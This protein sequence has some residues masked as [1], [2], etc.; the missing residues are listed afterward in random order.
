MLE[1]TDDGYPPVSIEE[2][3]AE[4]I[5]EKTFRLTGIPIFAYGIAPGDVI[6]GGLGEDGRLWAVSVLTPGDHWVARIVPQNRQMRTIEH[7]AALGQQFELWGCRT[8]PSSF[9]LLAVD[10]PPFVGYDKVIRM[11]EEKQAAGEWYFDLG[12]D[13]R[14]KSVST[15]EL[16]ETE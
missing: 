11:L 7:L 2:I 1:K 15:D 5:D 12:V 3:D 9:G 10:F 14:S 4:I 13:P 6:S 16:P 8:Q